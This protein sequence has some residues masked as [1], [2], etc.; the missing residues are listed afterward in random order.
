MKRALKIL[1]GSQNYMLDTDGSDE[2]Y[3]LILLPS[4]DDMYY[5]RDLNSPDNL[6]QFLRDG[7]YSCMD[8]R[9]WHELLKRGNINALE[10]L[11]STSIENYIRTD[12]MAAYINTM[13]A[14][15]KAGY[16]ASVWDRFY[17]S[18]EGV[19]LNAIKRNGVN[20][21]TIS[22]AL[23]YYNFAE[24]MIADNFQVDFKT[25]RNPIVCN[26]AKRLRNGEIMFKIEENQEENWKVAFENL[27]E[28]SS[29]E[30]KKV[31]NEQSRDYTQLIEFADELLKDLIKGEM[32]E[33]E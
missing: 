6:P 30:L 33:N 24:Y 15:F 7:H 28:R 10:Y 11:F 2:D 14:L 19:A 12:S 5:K 31:L 9:Q 1:Y 16:L 3:K 17:A 4:F 8:I 27:K 21:K 32:F 22:R 13:R 25:W 23:Y 29:L 20:A 18:V 26:C